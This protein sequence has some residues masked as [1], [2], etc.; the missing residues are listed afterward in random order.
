M[1]ITVRFYSY[2]KDVADCSGTT[3]EMAEG[4]TVGDLMEALAVRFPGLKP[5]QGSALVA[6]GVDYQD[7]GLTL[8]PG[9]E[10]SPLTPAQGGYTQREV[11]ITESAIEERA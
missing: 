1:Q 9:D 7:R 2:F 10:V 3:Q 6:V 5:L 11:I 8:N 4:A